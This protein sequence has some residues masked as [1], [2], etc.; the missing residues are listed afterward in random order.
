MF[1]QWRLGDLGWGYKP[2]PWRKDARGT[3][4]FFD[5]RLNL[6]VMIV[7]RNDKLSAVSM[8]STPNRATIFCGTPY[9]TTV[10]ATRDKLIVVLGGVADEFDLEARAASAIGWGAF[11]DNPD[12]LVKYVHDRLAPAQQPELEEFLKRNDQ[13]VGAPDGRPPGHNG[14]DGIH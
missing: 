10:N 1:E 4:L 8:S 2:N 6:L 13:P 12:D 7:T 14:T 11:S 5:E 9:E 3:F